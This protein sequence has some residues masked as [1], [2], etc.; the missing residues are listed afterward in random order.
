MVEAVHAPCARALGSRPHPRRPQYVVDNSGRN[1]NIAFPSRLRYVSMPLMTMHPGWQGVRMRKVMAGADP[2][3]PARLVTI[4]A[5]WDD[6]AASALAAMVPGHKPI[7]LVEAAEAWIATFPDPTLHITLHDF[8]RHRRLA[9]T[10]PAWRGGPCDTFVLNLAAFH[11][12]S[13]GL[14]GDAL[15]AATRTVVAAFQASGAFHPTVAISG[16]AGSL[17]SLG[18]DYAS[19]DARFLARDI[20]TRLRQNAPGVRLIIAPPGPADALLG[21]ETGGI[22]PWFSPLGP[23][24]ALSQGARAWLAARGR[25]PEAALAALLIG[26]TVFPTT[27]AAAHAAMHDALAPL[28]DAL[29]ARPEPATPPAPAPLRRELPARHAGYTQ[30]ASVGGHKL[31]LRTGEYADGTLGEISL[32]LHKENAAFRALME[33]FCTAVSLGL[34][35]GVPLAEFVDAFTLTRFGPSGTV[36]GDSAVPQASSLL[37]Y[38]FRHLAANYLGRHDIPGPEPE[39]VQEPPLPLPLEMPSAGRPRHL[40]LVR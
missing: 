20:A 15:I 4:P 10:S 23:T 1:L 5:A 19:P 3:A 37:D 36:D 6:A 18:L 14:D 28:L 31:Y 21:I 38:M 34:Q 26:E 33:S 9:P 40:R 13:Q 25:S 17:V 12:P 11:E 7:H 30:R 27:D 8:L 16:L 24:G 35:H 29:P 39:E 22:A 2:D 32:A